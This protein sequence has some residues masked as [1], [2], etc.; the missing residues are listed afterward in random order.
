MIR[1]IF[2]LARHF[3]VGESGDAAA[4]Q[5]RLERAIYKGT[6]CGAWIK[7]WTDEVVIGSIVEGSDAEFT[8]SLQYPFTGE[9]FDMNLD[10]LEE[11]CADA[12]YRAN[13]EDDYED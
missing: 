10:F 5:A 6:D 7:C 11:Q 4:V 8:E 13:E 2:D 3:G 1:N 12:F 9:Q